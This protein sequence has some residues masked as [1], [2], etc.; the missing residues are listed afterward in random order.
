MFL[1]SESGKY[2][3]QEIYNSKK[4]EIELIK[5]SV[6]QNDKKTIAVVISLAEYSDAKKKFFADQHQYKNQNVHIFVAKYNELLE[7]ENVFFF[8][9]NIKFEYL[10]YRDYCYYVN[11]SKDDIVKNLKAKDKYDDIFFYL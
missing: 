9:D 3:E 8:E 10:F 11:L 6:A 2:I 7:F 1:E 5:K 4:R